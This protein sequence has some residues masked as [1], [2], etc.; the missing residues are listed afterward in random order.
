MNEAFDIVRRYSTRERNPVQRA[1]A[2]VALGLMADDASLK[3]LHE[4]A[5]DPELS[6]R[7]EAAI[8]L[9][10]RVSQHRVDTWKDRLETVRALRSITATQ[11]DGRNRLTLF[12]P[13]YLVAMLLP[14][15]IWLAIGYL[16]APWPAINLG[17]FDLEVWILSGGL[18][19]VSVIAA[20]LSTS[21]L[22]PQISL[23]DL[24]A[25]ARALLAPAIVIG[26]AALA[27]AYFA[28]EGEMGGE[29]LLIVLGLSALFVPIIRLEAALIR[30]L[31]P[32][33]PLSFIAG[34]LFAFATGV[35]YL[36]LMGV[37]TR[38]S[39]AG[40]SGFVV[41]GLPATMALAFTYLQADHLS[42]EILPQDASTAAAFQELERTKKPA[43]LGLGRAML[44][45]G[46]VALCIPGAA[47]LWRVFEGRS[48]TMAETLP[49]TGPWPN[50]ETLLLPAGH[51]VPFELDKPGIVRFD[52][53]HGRLSLATVT[54]GVSPF[55]DYSSY[56]SGARV[57]VAGGN[58]AWVVV[59]DDSSM[60]EADF[61]GTMDVLGF[62]AL[63]SGPFK[64]SEASSEPVSPPP[65]MRLNRVTFSIMQTEDPGTINLLEPSPE[66]YDMASNGFAVVPPGVDAAYGP[67]S[68]LYGKEGSWLPAYA[69]LGIDSSVRP[70]L[71]GD[72]PTLSLIQ[73]ANLPQYLKSGDIY[74]DIYSPFAANPTPTV[75]SLA[76]ALPES[77]GYG[78]ISKLEQL[79]MLGSTSTGDLV[80][81]IGGAPF[82]NVGIG[83]VLR[84]LAVR[85]GDNVA[86]EVI[87]GNTT[88]RD[89]SEDGIIYT[90]LPRD[91]LR[92]LPPAQ[93]VTGLL[94]EIRGL[95]GLPTAHLTGVMSGSVAPGTA[96]SSPLDSPPQQWLDTAN[97]P[98]NPPPEFFGYFLVV[99]SDG[100]GFPFGTIVQGDPAGWDQSSN[101][102]FSKVVDGSRSGPYQWV[103]PDN[104]IYL[105]DTYQ[106][107]WQTVFGFVGL[108]PLPFSPDDLSTRPVLTT[109]QIAAKPAGSFFMDVVGYG[110]GAGSIGRKDGSPGDAALDLVYGWG[111]TELKFP[112]SMVFLGDD[113][114]DPAW[115]AAALAI[116]QKNSGLTTYVEAAPA[117]WRP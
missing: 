19:L 75:W 33:T 99:Q 41:M 28:S 79:S 64:A 57:W 44:V 107:E 77:A 6:V 92:V 27:C 104:L 115:E 4:L 29:K 89:S 85:I 36:A 60:E 7:T 46:L 116:R 14:V 8:A 111:A 70:T 5:K 84:P 16:L 49:P 37:A 61:S 88:E 78:L 90:M 22:P 65:A 24:V 43:P 20:S 53:E 66:K 101:P 71:T 67:G 45:V 10:Q 72:K 62:L 91:T 38:T 82:A 98:R 25:E 80:V 106:P 59:E 40:A 1:N 94:S 86:L 110:F 52:A 30:M 11:L 63:R 112:D 108:P 58:H 23:A 3:L 95:P 76:A 32:A 50:G 109:A 93:D 34:L 21:S 42:E 113:K 81:Y 47:L 17:Q 74:H 96:V 114:Y 39:A 73:P 31:L 13:A 35:G 117:D 48:T 69:W 56:P 12:W 100:I 55:F 102:G 103:S 51:T 15:F 54:A 9:R 87:N 2:C 18:A 97:I 105:G 26:L 68:L 83:T